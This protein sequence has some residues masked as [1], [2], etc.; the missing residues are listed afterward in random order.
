M[1]SVAFSLITKT[2]T[3]TTFAS[4]TLG[5]MGRPVTTGLTYAGGRVAT[6]TDAEQSAQT[7]PARTTFSWTDPDSVTVARPTAT[8][9]YELLIA[10]DTYARVR[11]VLRHGPS[12]RSTPVHPRRLPAAGH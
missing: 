8:T 10:D 5:T 6:V 1:C 7:T 2:Q 12:A 9:G 4:G 11:S 3:L